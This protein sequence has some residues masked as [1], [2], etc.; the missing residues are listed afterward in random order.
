MARI[1]LIPLL[2]FLILC[3][4]SQARESPHL[5]DDLSV[6]SIAIE[7]PELSRQI[8]LSL[9]N[10]HDLRFHRS[11][12]IFT[13][14]AIRLPGGSHHGPG[15]LRNYRLGPAI[16]V[17]NFQQIVGDSGFG[18]HKSLEGRRMKIK[19]W[20]RAEATVSR[21]PSGVF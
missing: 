9:R 10:P 8:A 4:H 17:E 18:M 13:S 15:P 16:P 6:R 14:P 19:R 12:R 1:A 7:D 21:A 2:Y 11:H 20:E 5:T 3:L